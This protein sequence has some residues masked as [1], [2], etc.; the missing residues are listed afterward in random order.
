MNGKTV[1]VA[2]CD[3]ALVRQE[4]QKLRKLVDELYAELT[5]YYLAFKTFKESLPPPMFTNAGRLSRLEGEEEQKE[6]KKKR[7][8]R[9][10][11][12]NQCS[13]TKYEHNFLSNSKEI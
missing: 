11:E 10:L 6:R 4:N 3:C 7:A 5:K 9:R 13:G 2:Q 12:K 8:K 1:E